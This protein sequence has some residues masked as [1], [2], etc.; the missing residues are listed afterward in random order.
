MIE[1]P[2][3][4]SV[5]TIPSGG[6]L[7][8]VQL[9]D[10]G[11]YD[12]T[13]NA[14]LAAGDYYLSGDG[15]STDLL[16]ELCT[17][18]TAAI[19]ALGAPFASGYVYAWID[20][21]HKVNL[22]FVACSAAAAARPIKIVWTASAANL[23]L[24]LGFDATADDVLDATP[25]TKQADWHHAYGWYCDT[26]GNL[27]NKPIV[28]AISCKSVQARSLGGVVRTQRMSEFLRDS[29]ASLYMLTNAK[30]FSDG[31]AYGSTPPYPRSKN[32]PF[33]C[34]WYEIAGGK[35]FRFYRN[36][37]AELVRCEARAVGGGDGGG[38]E[39]ISPV[40]AAVDQWNSGHVLAESLTLT[41]AVL[42]ANTRTA[43]FL[44]IVDDTL[45]NG[46]DPNLPPGLAD[47]FLNAE[48]VGLLYP[49]HQTYVLNAAD[50]NTFAPEEI[51]GIDRFN[52]DFKMMRYSAP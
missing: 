17:K 35:Q 29:S 32:E 49:C 18:S 45:A 52:I 16:C 21:S 31:T 46:V 1:R 39:I 36:Y 8:R 19:R 9:S 3:L 27:Q 14:T 26:D 50:S 38:Y 28:D 4:L 25:L 5:I 13:A 33:E 20:T 6:W 24:A 47:G 10:A 51:P 43:P 41:D 30:T 37:S 7:F 2:K 15:D 40:P 34:L 22:H 48:P 11:A 23:A 12:H 42:G 44:S